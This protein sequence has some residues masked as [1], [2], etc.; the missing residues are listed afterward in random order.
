[1]RGESNELIM[2]WRD[3]QCGLRMSNIYTVWDSQEKG[4]TNAKKA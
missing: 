1:M 2:T 4:H 3:R